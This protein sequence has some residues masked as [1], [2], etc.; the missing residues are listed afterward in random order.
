MN[1]GIEKADVTE[2]QIGLPTKFLDSGIRLPFSTQ[3]GLAIF[4]LHPDGIWM[5]RCL[6]Q[7]LDTGTVRLQICTLVTTTCFD[8]L[9]NLKENI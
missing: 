4:E 2:R 7:V 5:V 3:A 6:S 1:I 9:A 8:A